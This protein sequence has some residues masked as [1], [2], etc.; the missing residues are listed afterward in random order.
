MGN[1]VIRQKIPRRRAL[2]SPHSAR[3]CGDLMHIDLLIA[4]FQGG[5]FSPGSDTRSSPRTRSYKRQVSSSDLTVKTKWSM[6]KI[7]TGEWPNC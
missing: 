2:G 6:E 4:E 5:G 7:M 1:T 3:M